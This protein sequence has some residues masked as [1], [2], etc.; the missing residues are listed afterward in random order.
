[1]VDRKL[2][3]VSRHD[4]RS[5]KYGVELQPV[6]PVKKYWT[7]GAVLDQGEEGACVGFGWTAELLASPMPATTTPAVGS[8]YALE[9]YKR[10]KLLDEFAGENYE[11][12]SVLAGAKVLQERGLIGGYRWCFNIE[13]VRDS[14][15]S[16]G[17]VVIGIP[18][19][20]G[21]YETRPSGLVDV[22]GPQVGGHCIALTG[23]NPSARL[24]GE[25]WLKRFEV[26]RWRNSWGTAYGN[27]G[28]GYITIEDLETLLKSTGEACVPTDRKPVSLKVY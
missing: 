7:E 4:V 12:T 19:L 14:V 27:N 3:W 11:G 18:W 23:Y 1:L 16:Q 25:G 26:F 6:K 28:S 10:A 9:V 17:P 20:D 22:S 15:V 13:D 24:A 21:M 8:T 5:L 2:D